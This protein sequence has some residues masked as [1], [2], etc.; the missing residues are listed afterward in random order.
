MATSWPPPT[1]GRRR[2]RSPQMQI[3][4]W[5]L[6]L[7]FHLARRRKKP[8]V[9]S[10]HSRVSHE[11]KKIPDPLARIGNNACELFTSHPKQSTPTTNAS[12][13]SLAKKQQPP[14]DDV[15]SKMYVDDPSYNNNVRSIL[16]PPNGD[17]DDDD[18][19]LSNC[20]TTTTRWCVTER[21]VARR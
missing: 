18:N 8:N 6:S 13:L 10:A 9:K 21:A 5:F 15:V 2:C 16:E 20:R 17:D 12:R 19:G 14:C 7:S 3:A 1:C 4:D 11:T